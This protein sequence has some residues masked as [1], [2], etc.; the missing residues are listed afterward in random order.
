M[1][2]DNTIDNG[3]YY[4]MKENMLPISYTTQNKIIPKMLRETNLY[5]TTLKDDYF[6]VRINI[7]A[8]ELHPYI[9]KT[10]FRTNVTICV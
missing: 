6:T 8:R 2:K 3:Y 10:C 4:S 5:R 7:I 1:L 9:T